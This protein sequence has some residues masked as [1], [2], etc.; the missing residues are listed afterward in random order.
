M[1]IEIIEPHGMCAGV[2]AATASVMVTN[3]SIPNNPVFYY[4]GTQMDN[5]NASQ[6]DIWFALAEYVPAVSSPIGGN[7]TAP[8]QLENHDLNSSLYRNGWGRNSGV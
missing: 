7:S 2:N 4:P 6:D 8:S 3:G 5:R 1:R